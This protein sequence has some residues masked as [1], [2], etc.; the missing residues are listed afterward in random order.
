MARS[1]TQIDQA[2]RRIRES[3][4]R[5]ETA[6][7]A[8]VATVEDFR[9]AHLD[10]TVK[11]HGLVEIM[12][13]PLLE[14]AMGVV[15]EERAERLVEI[16]SRPKTTGAMIAKLTRSTI[17]LTKMQDIAGARIVV[18]SLEVQDIVSEWLV[19]GLENE[20][21]RQRGVRFVR[22]S[23]SREHGDALGYRAVH[24][25]VDWGGRLGEVQIRTAAQQV[26]AQSV[27]IADQIF[28]TDL[29]HGVGA[30]DWLQWMLDYSRELRKADLDQPYS[31]P[32]P[33][34]TD[35]HA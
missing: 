23:D 16:A 34:V 13:G 25:I 28:G 7:E 8:D 5:G 22:M 20:D 27:E 19:T 12:R 14:A 32:T 33:P 2:G 24:V 9:A 10:T 21:L 29:K 11:L 26:W 18:P 17:R 15:G 30:D 1:R 3:L 35:P 31:M 6:R 4:R